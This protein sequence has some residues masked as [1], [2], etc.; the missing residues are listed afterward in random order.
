MP[1]TGFTRMPANGCAKDGWIIWRRSCIGLLTKKHK[2]SPCFWSGG[3]SK[4]TSIVTCG[5]G[6]SEEHTSELQSRGHLVCRHP[7]EKKNDKSTDYDRSQDA[8]MEC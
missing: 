4:T 1:L 3:T 2:V 8:N 6:R 7:L 5:R